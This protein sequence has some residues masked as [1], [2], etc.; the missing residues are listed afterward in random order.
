M[1][2]SFL[3][4]LALIFAGS[5]QMF[6]ALEDQLILNANG[7]VCTINVSTGNVVTTAGAC[8]NLNIN[9]TGDHGQINVSSKVDP[10]TK[11][12]LLFNGFQVGT[13]AFGL[14]ATVGG[15]QALNQID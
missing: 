9:S 15:L 6:A 10:V 14:F 12:A 13:S 3:M 4:G 5:T 11:K 1:K 2:R 7:S 8:A